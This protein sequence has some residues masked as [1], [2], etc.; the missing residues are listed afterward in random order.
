MKLI[1]LISVA[2]LSSLAAHVYADEM[3]QQEGIMIHKT[4][5]MRE[6]IEG[7]KDYF[8]GRV[9]IDPYHLEVREPSKLTSALVTFEPGAR[10][11]WHTHPLGQL[12]IVTSGKGWTQCEG[13]EKVE[14]GEGDT[15]WCPPNHKHWHGAT[16][17][18]G[19]SHIAVQEVLNG[20]NVNWL[21]PVS[22]ED[23]LSER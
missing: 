11:N 5:D 10:T 14:V 16:S 7:P 9:W 21:E 15:I 17:S 19:M 13:E 18:S 1:N 22:D 3:N 12:L 6:V 20:T 2:V 8:T 4:K 23:Y